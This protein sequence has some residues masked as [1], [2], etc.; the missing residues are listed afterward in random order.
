M[1][2]NLRTI[3]WIGFAAFGIWWFFPQ[4]KGLIKGSVVESSEP[5]EDTKP[6]DSTN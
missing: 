4:I 3:M 1:V 5:D 2:E 6:T